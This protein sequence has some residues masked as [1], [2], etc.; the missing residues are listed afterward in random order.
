M[1]AAAL[2]LRWLA[3]VQETMNTPEQRIAMERNAI[4]RANPHVV[5]DIGA[6]VGDMTRMFLDLGAN[7]VVCVEPIP[8]VFDRLTSAFVNDS[9]VL[10]LNLAVT[11]EADLALR[12]G[13]LRDQSV[14][15]CYTLWPRA[16]S[17][18][19]ESSPEYRNKPTFDV[20]LSTIDRIVAEHRLCPNFIKIDV[21]G[22][23]VKAMRGAQETI[24][25]MRPV[26]ML[27]ISYL[28][29]F[30]GDSCEELMTMAMADGYKAESMFDGRIFDTAAEFMP[31][32]PWNTSFDLILWPSEH[33]GSPA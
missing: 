20:W 22:Y 32:F 23:E 6:N 15:N 11:D 3:D 5:L 1:D 8:D 31:M 30:F 24:R 13:M 18:G 9:R 26:I 21:D 4:A 29:K 12:E 27:E 10:T 14:F 2:R 17:V 16:K 7:H 19:L 33:P 25:K 28:P